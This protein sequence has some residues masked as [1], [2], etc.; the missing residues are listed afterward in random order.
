MVLDP[1]RRGPRRRPRARRSGRPLTTAT[2]SAWPR[3]SPMVA[4]VQPGDGRGGRAASC[5]QQLQN[6]APAMVAF[7]GGAP[8]DGAHLSVG[9]PTSTASP[10]A[11]EACSC[12]ATSTEIAGVGVPPAFRRARHRRGDH[13][14]ARRG[15]RPARH[16]RPRSCRRATRRSA[17]STSGSASARSAGLAPRRFRGRGRG[18][19]RSARSPRRRPGPSGPRCCGRAARPRR[20]TSRT[21][22]PE[23]STPR[24]RRR[25]RSWPSAGCRA[26]HPARRRPPGRVAAA[27][28]GDAPPAGTRGRRRR[29]GAAP[30]AGPRAGRRRRCGG[31]RGPGRPFYERAGFPA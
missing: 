19:T 18:Q 15:A 31:T 29:P 23:P 2:T 14:A 25:A 28:D 12:W 4:F 26:R 9:R 7:L 6:V 22:R 20:S 27:G 17:A 16:P 10:S 3:R 8:A 1:D 21:T 5:D 24:V 13:V 11:W 30:G